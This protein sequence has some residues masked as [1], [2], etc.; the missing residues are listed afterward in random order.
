MFGVN[1]D[2]ERIWSF[3]LCLGVKS[4]ALVLYA[5]AENLDALKWWLGVFIAPTTKPTVG[6]GLLSMGAPDSPVRQPRHPTVRVR[7]LELCQPSPPDS[8]VVHRTVTVHCLVCLLAPALTLRKLSA[9]CS[10]FQVS[11]GVD[12]C[13]VAVA[14]LAHRTVR[15]IIVEWLFQKP[16][17]GKFEVD[18]P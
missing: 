16:E 8:P 1:L 11:V 13:V 17:G 14:P 5:M 12:H 3:D 2:L 10:T 4:R 6:V 9:H 7:P 15:W 18:Q